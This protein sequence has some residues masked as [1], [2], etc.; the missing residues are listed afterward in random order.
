MSGRNNLFPL[1]LLV[2]SL[3]FILAGGFIFVLS[4]VLTKL[5]A[6]LSKSQSAANCNR[7]EVNLS[8]SVPGRLIASSIQGA[9]GVAT[10]ETAP[11]EQT[12]VTFNRCTGVVTQ[13][14]IIHASMPDGAKP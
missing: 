2:I 12:V 11:G 8:L 13:T 10:F 14:L 4:V 7:A 9:S 3:G 5:P 6:S 1:K